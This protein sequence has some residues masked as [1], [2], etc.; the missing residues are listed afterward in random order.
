MDIQ[1]YTQHQICHTIKAP[2]GTSVHARCPTPHE[3][4]ALHKQTLRE[5]RGS[6]Q[7]TAP[8][9]CHW[10]VHPGRTCHLRIPHRHR[11]FTAGNFRTGPAREQDTDY[12]PTGLRERVHTWGWDRSH[13]SP[14]PG[15]EADGAW[16]ASDQMPQPVSMRQVGS[17]CSGS[18]HPG[19][20]T[21]LGQWVEEV[22]PRGHTAADCT[23][24]GPGTP[25]TPPPDPAVSRFGMGSPGTLPL[26]PLPT[27]SPERSKS[28]KVLLP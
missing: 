27:C 12:T 25:V 28:Q 6:L 21:D 4:C 26:A 9:N 7:V 17:W 1:Y 13:L 16:L 23:G 15:W 14:H 10:P 19:W 20:E 24:P 8:Q 18:H 3:K 22:G 2:S 5:T 11:S